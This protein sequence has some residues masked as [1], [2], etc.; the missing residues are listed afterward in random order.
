MRSQEG[1]NSWIS[2]EMKEAEEKRRINGGRDRE[3]GGGP[4]E[5]EK[6]QS[7]R[8]MRIEENYDKTGQTRRQKG[9]MKEVKIKGG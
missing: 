3:D 4:G 2:S 7:E 5:K 8:R 6:R 1:G 9:R